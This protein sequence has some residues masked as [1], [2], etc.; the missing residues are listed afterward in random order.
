MS[1][2]RRNPLAPFR[3]L[4][5]ILLALAMIWA[6]APCAEARSLALVVGNDAYRDV[7]KL[8]TAD[9]DAAIRN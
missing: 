5:A 6:I 1:R 7:P 2:R 4:P 8:K 3:H 9:G